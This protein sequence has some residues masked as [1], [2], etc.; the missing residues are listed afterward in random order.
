M[1]G[2]RLPR[3]WLSFNVQ[4][5]EIQLRSESFS[6]SASSSSVFPF[7][8]IKLPHCAFN[9]TRFALDRPAA[10]EPRRDGELESELM[11]GADR[12]S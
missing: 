8:V 9:R 12:V 7:I 1:P 6:T 4:Q 2:F 5:L 10:Y 11:I 3:E